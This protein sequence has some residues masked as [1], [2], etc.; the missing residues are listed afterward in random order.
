M[1]ICQSA[2]EGVLPA[3]L[4]RL[5]RPICIYL[6]RC[7]DFLSLRRTLSTPHSRRIVGALYLD[8]S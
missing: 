1:D 7:H 5:G 3:R 8:T 4:L 2:A 6:L